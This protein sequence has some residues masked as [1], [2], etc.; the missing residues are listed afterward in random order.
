MVMEI[1]Q[2]GLYSWKYCRH[3]GKHNALKSGGK[4]KLGDQNL[5]RKV[6][7]KVERSNELYTNGRCLD[8]YHYNYIRIEKSAC[9]MS[10]TCDM[11]L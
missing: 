4:L 11:S 3:V 6:Q 1:K 8:K 7:H 9:D 5:N 10:V 2:H